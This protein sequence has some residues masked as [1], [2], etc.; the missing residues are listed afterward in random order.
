MD[1][2]D[3]TGLTERVGQMAGSRRRSEQIPCAIEKIR[4]ND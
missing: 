3:S 1:V 2:E 4:E